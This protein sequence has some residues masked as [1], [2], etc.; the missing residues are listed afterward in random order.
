MRH[1]SV[2]TNSLGLLICVFI[3]FLSMC[4]WRSHFFRRDSVWH[5][6]VPIVLAH[7]Q[8][9]V[10]SLGGLPFICSS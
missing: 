6:L 2:W 3:L 1:D 10:S 4:S 9:F 8:K 7:F 5:D